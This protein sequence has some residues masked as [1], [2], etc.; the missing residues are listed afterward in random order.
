[1]NAMSTLKSRLEEAMKA[2]PEIRQVDLARACSVKPPSVD[3]WFR[4]KAKTMNSECVFPVA[5]LLKINAR[6]LCTGKGRKEID[7]GD[8]QSSHS[9]MA[10]A[11]ADLVDDL[12]D[13][14]PTKIGRIGAAQQA[15]AGPWPQT[16]GQPSA[17]P[18]LPA[19]AKKARA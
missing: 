2:R 12:P 7:S 10:L 8:F 15:L 11:V 18:A 14:D 1:M 6:W 4:G 13:Q 19:K 5:D 3:G 16:S 9:H 17:A